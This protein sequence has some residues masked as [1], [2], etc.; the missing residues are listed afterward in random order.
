MARVYLGLGSNLDSARY[1][2]EGL[3]ELHKQFG[4]LS[5]S[6]IFESESIGFQ[7]TIFLN[8]VVGVDTDLP[9]GEL[10]N[11]C[12][13]VERQSGHDHS[14]PKFSPRTLDIDILLY[15]DE[16]GEIAGVELPRAEITENAFVLWPLA[17]LIPN[18]QHPVLNISFQT[19]W[20]DYKKDQR[21][22]PVS[23]LWR[24]RSLPE[25]VLSPPTYSN[26]E[27]K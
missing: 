9:V 21:L 4:E 12:K 8:M 19:L 2:T 16:V 5:L 13:T 26:S 20:R 24:S 7:G 1:I 23:F 17:E 11:W 10:D 22:W 6:P 15:D 3:D 18:H 25:P 27:R 14:S